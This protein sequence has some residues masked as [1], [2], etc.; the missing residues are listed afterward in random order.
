MAIPAPR[1]GVVGE[2]ASE[3]G[4]S[5]VSGSP[6]RGSMDESIEMRRR[7]ALEAAERRMRQLG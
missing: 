3:P 1:G 7:R 6:L 5:S 2:A 4:S